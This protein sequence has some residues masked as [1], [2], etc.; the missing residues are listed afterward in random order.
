[1]VAN[2]DSRLA[3]HQVI[4]HDIQLGHD[5]QDVQADAPGEQEVPQFEDFAERWS[6][7]AECQD[8][9]EGVDLGAKIE[10]EKVLEEN[11]VDRFKAEVDELLG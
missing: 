2:D 1:M 3:L 10:R 9:G 11:W 4:P 6:R 5:T 7:G 8:R